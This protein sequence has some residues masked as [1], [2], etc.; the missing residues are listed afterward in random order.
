MRVNFFIGLLRPI[1]FNFAYVLRSTGKRSHSTCDLNKIIALPCCLDH[2]FDKFL[3]AYVVVVAV[4]QNL[5]P[6]FS[7]AFLL[8]RTGLHILGTICDV[9]FHGLNRTMA[10]LTLKPT[11]IHCGSVLL[12]LHRMRKAAKTLDEELL[13]IKNFG[14]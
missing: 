11:S 1:F 2:V 4:I 13:A 14:Q 7:P 8:R 12:I 9:N 10:L 6:F 3:L 5:Y